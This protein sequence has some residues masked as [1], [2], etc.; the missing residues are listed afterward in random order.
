[1]TEV[2]NPFDGEAVRLVREQS[3]TLQEARD[4]VVLRYLKSGNTQALAHW[5]MTDY[6]PGRTVALMLSYMLQ[7]ERQVEGGEEQIVTC[8]PEVVPFEL[9]AKR[10]TRNR[11]RKFDSIAAERNQAIYDLYKKL[12]AD[13]GPGGS[14][15][16][17]AELEDLLGPEISP[18]MIK[19]AVKV[20]T[21]K[22]GRRGSK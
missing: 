3:V 22:S 10:R 19:E 21:P 8:S 14:D 13:I 5:L 15:S 12:L 1:M 7:P 17:I 6:Q 2:D 9:K 16:A 11:G 4:A 20:R 18:S